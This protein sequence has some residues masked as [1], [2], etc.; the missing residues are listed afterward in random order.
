MAC[1]TRS[2]VAGIL[3][4]RTPLFAPEF[5]ELYVT[6]MRLAGLPEG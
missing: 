2:G 6:G 3:I 4:W 1:H 5:L